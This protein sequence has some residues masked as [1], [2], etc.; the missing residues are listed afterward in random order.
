MNLLPVIFALFGMGI[1]C[2][3]SRHNL[4]KL[5]IGLELLGKATTLAIV[6]SGVIRN[7]LSYTQSLALVVIAIE[8]MVV[9][10]FLALM[11]AFYRQSGTLDTDD[12]R[13]LK[14]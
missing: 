12:L 13:R 4:I 6:W 10:V 9:A 5:L 1:Y 14:G 2:L 3:L 11:F 7:T 8:V